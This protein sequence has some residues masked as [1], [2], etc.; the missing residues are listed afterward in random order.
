MAIGIAYIFQHA[1]CRSG[2]M[3]PQERFGFQAEIVSITIWGK[4]ARVG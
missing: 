1:K 2:G 3:L 4:I